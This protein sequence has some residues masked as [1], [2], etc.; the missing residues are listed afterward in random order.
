MPKIVFSLNVQYAVALFAAPIFCI[1]Y[2]SFFPTQDIDIFW[3]VN[4]PETFL[5][6]ILFY[7]VVEELAFRGVIQE[8]LSQK[9]E[10]NSTLLA[11]S[12]ANFITSILFVSLHLFHHPIIWALLTFFPSLIFGYFKE[13]FDH[14]LPSI[15]LHMFYN[16]AYFLMIGK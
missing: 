3:F 14:I 6:A 16:F 11:I 2:R 15:I 13:R 5:M 10:P 1:L 4:H 12:Y 7:P 9:L 8:F